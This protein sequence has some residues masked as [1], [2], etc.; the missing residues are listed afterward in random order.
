MHVF[1]EGRVNCRLVSLPHHGL[2]AVAEQTQKERDGTSGRGN[3]AQRPRRMA[4]ADDDGWRRAVEEDGAGRP[5]R[6]AESG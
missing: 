2:E 6:M 1:Q 3:G 4:H 5:R